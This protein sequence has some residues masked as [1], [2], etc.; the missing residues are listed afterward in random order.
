MTKWFPS[1][2]RFLAFSLGNGSPNNFAGAVCR[3]GGM[4][5]WKAQLMVLWDFSKLSGCLEFTLPSGA[6]ISTVI[7]FFHSN[8]FLLE[9]QT[10]GP[11][12][13]AVQYK[14]TIHSKSIKHPA[15]PQKLCLGAFQSVLIS[16]SQHYVGQSSVRSKGCLGGPSSPGFS[17]VPCSHQPH[18]TLVSSSSWAMASRSQPRELLWRRVRESR[19]ERTSSGNQT[20]SQ[21]AWGHLD[22]P[23]ALCG[24]NQLA[25]CSLQC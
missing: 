16:V 1:F 6:S 21:P 13:A 20:P 9:N 18:R 10:S 24:V 3:D 11:G 7:T 15:Q 4:W 17:P 22:S 25:A 14:S 19:A 23:A 12:Q 8:D 2:G 5:C